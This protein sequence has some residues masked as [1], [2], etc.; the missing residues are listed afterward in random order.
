MKIEIEPDLCWQIN[1]RLNLRRPW[2]RW[3]HQVPSGYHNIYKF[4]FMEMFFSP[5]SSSSHSFR[6]RGWISSIYRPPR[7]L[8]DSKLNWACSNQ[9]VS[10][11]KYV[12]LDHDVG[13][14]CVPYMFLEV[15]FFSKNYNY[16][17]NLKDSDLRMQAIVLSWKKLGLL[18]PLRV[19]L[20]SG[21]HPRLM[22]QRLG[23]HVLSFL[24]CFPLG[25]SWSLQLTAFAVHQF[26]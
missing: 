14:C 11:A 25:N 19:T 26:A 6:R 1:L 23:C 2:W 12:I 9:N 17:T 15:L 22:Y 7:R 8:T 4:P 16:S 3:I 18:S 10:T 24:S 20:H 13:N 5:P 21:S